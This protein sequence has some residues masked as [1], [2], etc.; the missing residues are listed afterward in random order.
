MFGSVVGSLDWIGLDL[1]FSI[2]RAAVLNLAT[3]F[4]E[5]TF[6]SMKF[7]YFCKIHLYECVLYILM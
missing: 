6:H 3:R 1:M 4:E 2:L 7:V 5:Q